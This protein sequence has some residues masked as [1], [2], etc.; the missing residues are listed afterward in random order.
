MAKIDYRKFIQEQFLILNKEG[1][2][3]PFRLFPV[4]NKYYE[5]LMGDYGSKLEGV[6]EIVL[7]ARQEGFSSLIL[8]MFTVDF[9]TLPNSISICISHR[10]DITQILFKRVKFY[11]ESYCQR[12]EWD[13]KD[14][15]LTDNKAEIQNRTNG[16]YFYIGTAGSKVGGRGGTATNIHF[17][18]AAFYQ[19]TE[20]IT[21][22]EIIE[23][24]SQ[25]V[26][27]DYGK[28]FVESTGN[29]YGDYFQLMW[30]RASRGEG[31]FHSRF[32]NW[33]EFYD[34]EWFEK[35]RGDFESD[36]TFKREY[37]TTPMDAFL[38]SGTPFFDLEALKKLL[39]NVSD[40][41]KQGRLAQ[42]GQFI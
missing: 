35:K 23:A 10:R 41:I 42:D 36:A 18:E 6:R 1:Q 3:V 31:N 5:I 22:K 9:I 26:P 14:Y 37:P 20:K 11:L 13:I 12:N 39:A 34:R 7:K 2:I 15:L 32:F 40:P 19:D 25:Q 8:A 21:A 30:E 33:E 27:Q 4:Q 29:Q 16:A 17:S 24:T 38:S 28:I